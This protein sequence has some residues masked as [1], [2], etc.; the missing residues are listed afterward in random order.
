MNVLLRLFIK[1][2][3]LFYAIEGTVIE[4]EMNSIL[5]CPNNLHNNAHINVLLRPK[6]KIFFI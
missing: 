5:L 4:L 1:Y 6:Y 3:I 2:F